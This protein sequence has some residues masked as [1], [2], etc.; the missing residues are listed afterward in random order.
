MK[1]LY[2]AHFVEGS[3]WSTA[4]IN[5]VLALDSVGVDVV[6]RNLKL[7]EAKHEIPERIAQLS[8][9]NLKDVDVCI[10]HVLPH[11][12]VG[13]EK[14]KKNIAY[15]ATESN[16]IRHLSWY[17]NLKLVDEVWVPSRCNQDSLLDDGFN[18]PDPAV[19]VVPHPFDV[20]SY[21]IDSDLTITMGSPSSF[22]FYYIGDLNDRKNIDSIIRCFHSEFKNGEDVELFLK[23]NKSGV[24]P[25][26]CQNIVEHKCN[27]IKKQLR[28]YPSINDYRKEIII[29]DFIP[30][31]DIQKLHMALDCFVHPSHGEGFSIPSFEAMLYGNTPICSNEG[32]P[33][34]FIDPED[35][36]T[37]TLVEGVYDICNHSDP[38][39]SELSTG[40]E[41][42]FHPSES[43]T[44][45][46]MRKY[47]EM[48]GK[49]DKQAGYKRAKNNDF[50]EIGNLMMGFINE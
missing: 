49:V 26:S 32:G 16:T 17:N 43:K 11:F 23:V 48:R 2:I 40:R 33:R 22:K 21:Q 50:K 19:R 47:Y 39:F 20:S 24:D 4:A 9:K 42:W 3:G 6:C 12:I 46:A 5:N 10:Q 14:F 35:E 15:F 27:E 45:K 18:A 41:E 25:R 37:G 13:T 31:E 28:I 34:D 8:S 29:S 7:T 38:A 30:S 1:V 36:N 44:K